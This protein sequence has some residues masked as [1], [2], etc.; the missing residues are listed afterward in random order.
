LGNKG[1]IMSDEKPAKPAKE[2]KAKPYKEPKP[3][4]KKNA[5]GLYKKSHT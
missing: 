4:N 3:K 2:K 5:P 1:D